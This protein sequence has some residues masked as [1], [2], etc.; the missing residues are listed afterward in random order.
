MST[1]ASIQASIAYRR[2]PERDGCARCAH[3][4][5]DAEA[6]AKG[7]K[8]H[9]S[10]LVQTALKCVLTSVEHETR[11]Q[12]RFRGQ[13][14]FGPHFNVEQLATLCKQGDQALEARA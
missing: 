13:A 11:E 2:A 10:E 5:Y 8:Y 4:V 7:Q 6:A 1:I 9:S 14:I 12:F 3:V